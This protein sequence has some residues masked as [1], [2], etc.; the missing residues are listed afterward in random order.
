MDKRSEVKVFDNKIILLFGSGISVEAGF[1]VSSDLTKDLLNTSIF[2]KTTSGSYNWGG[3][4]NTDKVLCCNQ[5]YKGLLIVNS[6]LFKELGKA[7]NYEEIYYY[8]RLFVQ[9]RRDEYEDFYKYIEK[10]STLILG[11]RIKFDNSGF[12]KA[13]FLLHEVCNYIQHFIWNRLS[14][15]IHDTSY[16]SLLKEIYDLEDTDEINIFTLNHDLV[17]E[18]FFSDNNIDYIDGFE[19][20]N[21][22]IDKEVRFWDPEQYKKQSRIKLYKLHGSINWIVFDNESEPEKLGMSNNKDIYHIKKQGQY[23]IPSNGRPLFLTGTDNKLIDYNSNQFIQFYI[24]NF[25]EVLSRYKKIIVS[26][27]SYG[28]IG[29]NKILRDWLV[30]GKFIVNVNKEIPKVSFAGNI[31]STGKYIQDTFLKDVITIME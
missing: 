27:Y 26:G 31:K 7:P 11:E 9:T 2:Y 28:D 4:N 13:F 24:Q 29:I 1:P 30:D 25:T 10:Q 15:N 18:K 3:R 20:D 17:L 14:L 12:Q 23:L 5:V 19:K 8:C 21:S 16:L 6:Y 22:E